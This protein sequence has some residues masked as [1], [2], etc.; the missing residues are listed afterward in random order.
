M[1]SSE[2]SLNEA[3]PVIRFGVTEQKIEE[4]ENRMQQCG[5]LEKDIEETFVR[6]RGAGGQKVNKTSSCVQ[7]K[8]IPTG[9]AVKVQQSRSQG[10]NRFFARRQL[11]ELLEAK[12]LGKDSPKA[13]KIQK[14]RKQKDRRSRRRTA[15]QRY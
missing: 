5:L 1:R 11:C 8:H 7:L 10:M 4:L 9:L 6:S 14:I 13:R 15:L 2:N 12:L 3:Q